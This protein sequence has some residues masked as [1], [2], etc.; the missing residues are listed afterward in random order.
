MNYLTAPFQIDAKKVFKAVRATP[1]HQDCNVLVL[2]ILK[3][4]N[5][6]LAEYHIDNLLGHSKN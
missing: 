5:E 1:E 4:I 3:E 2:A 6:Q